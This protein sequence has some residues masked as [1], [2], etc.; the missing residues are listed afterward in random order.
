MY[1]SSAT[2]GNHPKDI[3][4][5]PSPGYLVSQPF[6]AG[7]FFLGPVSWACL[8][9]PNET[10]VLNDYVL[11]KKIQLFQNENFQVRS[12]EIEGEPWFAG[13]DVCRHLGIVNPRTSLS[14][15]HNDEKGVHTMYTPSGFQDMVIINLPGLFHL[16][17][18]MRI[19]RRMREDQ[20]ERV[21][22]IEK[23]R[24]WVNHEVLPTLMKTGSYTIKEP[25]P[26][27]SQLANIKAAL[28]IFDMA[29]IDLEENDQLFFRDLTKNT[30]LLGSGQQGYASPIDNEI[31]ISGRMSEL[32]FRFV[33][34]IQRKAEIQIGRKMAKAFRDA[35]DK[36]PPTRTA[37]V[38]GQPRAIKA[39]RREHL[40]ILDPIIDTVC[41]AFGEDN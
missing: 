5:N 36:E 3:F 41:A 2:S 18:T 33:R 16:L 40:E 27:S 19:S 21:E 1:F 34:K 9:E 29:G 15:L 10:L 4:N 13:A 30:L 7:G 11:S 14:R 31:T 26:P 12:L 39:Y 8:G 6:K 17:N 35:Y 38:D 20:P 37:Y 24:H 28:E 25:E 23:F 32:G 22:T